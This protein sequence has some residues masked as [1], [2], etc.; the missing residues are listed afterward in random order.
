MNESRMLFCPFCKEA[1][2]DVTRCPS[3]DVEL[4]SLRELGVVAAAG[5]PDDAP[6]PVWSLQRGRGLLGFGALLTWVAFFFPLA[7]LFGDLRVTNTMFTLARGRALRLWIVPMAAFALLLMLYR[8]RSG[9]AMRGARMAALFLSLLPSGVVI[10]TLFGTHEAAQRLAE[11][12]HSNVQLH[13]G[14]GA[15]LVGLASIPLVWG[16]AVLGVRPKP[17]V[18]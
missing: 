1:F 7:S 3:H 10:F 12:L 8:R 18:R 16:S 17:R 5:A 14:L 15:W 4:V 9:P 13:I 2:D 6:L 11:Q